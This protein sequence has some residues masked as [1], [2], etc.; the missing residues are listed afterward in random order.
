MSWDQLLSILKENKRVERERQWREPIACPNDG[1]PLE[2]TSGGLLHCPWGDYTYPI[3]PQMP[4]A[5]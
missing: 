1:T 4:E 5:C 2:R 3:E